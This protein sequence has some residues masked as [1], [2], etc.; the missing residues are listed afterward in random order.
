MERNNVFYDLRQLTNLLWQWHATWKKL[1][2]CL[3]CF[4]SSGGQESCSS[5]AK[6]NLV[7]AT[8]RKFGAVCNCVKKN[9]KASRNCCIICIKSKHLREHCIYNESWLN[10]KIE[11]VWHLFVCPLILLLLLIMC[12]TTVFVCRRHI[13]PNEFP[14]LLRTL[15]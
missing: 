7:R 15:F 6:N 9:A 3:T 13:D 11:K 5:F 2:L 8:F 12:N 10:N 14:Y 4:N 1:N